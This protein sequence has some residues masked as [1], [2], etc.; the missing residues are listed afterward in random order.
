[1]RF[2]ISV[3]PLSLH[4]SELQAW[5]DVGPP[6]TPDQMRRGSSQ[7][8]NDVAVVHAPRGTHFTELRP[9]RSYPKM[10]P[11]SATALRVAAI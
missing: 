7:S 1:M 6:Y 4:S 8:G 5:D 10:S 2:S 3:V 11:V 9:A